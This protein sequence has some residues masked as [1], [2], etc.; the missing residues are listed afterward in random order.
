MVF[1]S[2]AE[3][4]KQGTLHL[5]D[6]LIFLTN[7][8]DTA[9]VPFF[10]FPFPVPLAPSSRSPSRH[11]VLPTTPLHSLS[12]YLSV[13][14]YPHIPLNAPLLPSPWRY[15]SETRAHTT[16][17]SNISQPAPPRSRKTSARI[18]PSI[19]MSSAIS[20]LPRSLTHRPTT[21]RI[22][23]HRTR[24]IRSSASTQMA[25]KTSACWAMSSTDSPHV[26]TTIRRSMMLPTLPVFSCSTATSW[27]QME[28]RSLCPSHQHPSI[29][30]LLF[31]STTALRP[32]TAT[33]HHAVGR[34]PSHRIQIPRSIPALLH[35]SMLLT[36]SRNSTLNRLT[37]RRIISRSTELHR[38]Q[39][40]PSLP[41][42]C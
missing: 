15:S 27:I 16:T 35:A 20:N 4:K 34:H 14:S 8:P 13:L 36:P 3:V 40:R 18:P 5:G 32:A 41:L 10:P 12:L 25:P 6:G 42:S 9:S 7:H 21:A 2:V 39:R 1:C 37:G 28:H 24:A 22:K 29:S 26:M 11:P 19:L 17:T 30:T 33:E 23:T 38:H 31:R